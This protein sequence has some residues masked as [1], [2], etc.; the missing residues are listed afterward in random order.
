MCCNGGRLKGVCANGLNQKNFHAGIFRFVID[1]ATSH[2]AKL[3]SELVAGYPAKAGI[4][5]VKTKG[6]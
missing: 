1:K 2:S 3:A 5:R 6:L 4:Q